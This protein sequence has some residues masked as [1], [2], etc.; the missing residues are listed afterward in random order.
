MPLSNIFV[1]RGKNSQNKAKSSPGEKSAKTNVVYVAPKHAKPVKIELQSRGW[2]DKDFRMIK[3][4][5]KSRIAIPVTSE[6]LKAMG[7]DKAFNTTVDN[8]LSEET[9]SGD[10]DNEK[11]N[12]KGWA[13]IG[14]GE[15]DM[16]FSTA[17]FASGK[18]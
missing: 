13:I 16:P 10:R 18:R 7:E 17:K 6:G 3:I 1:S 4:D 8:S 9:N 5:N 15:E 12:E 2:L 14:T 11:D